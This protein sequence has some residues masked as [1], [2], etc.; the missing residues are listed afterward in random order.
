MTAALGPMA[1]AFGS[2]AATIF[3]QFCLQFA[4]FQLATIHLAAVQVTPLQCCLLL[5]RANIT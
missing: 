4:T 5:Q 3:S 1:M 2:M